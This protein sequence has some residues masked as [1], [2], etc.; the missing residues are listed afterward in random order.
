[1]A[2]STPRWVP[3]LLV[4][5]VVLLPFVS[6][7]GRVAGAVQV[8]A[9]AVAFTGISVAVVSGEHARD[10]TRRPVVS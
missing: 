3:A 7:L 10:L 5:F 1:M 2:G 9:L 4:V 8:M 6:E